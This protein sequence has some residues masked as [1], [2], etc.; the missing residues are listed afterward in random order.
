MSSE[1]QTAAAEPDVCDL[2][3]RALDKAVAVELG[4]AVEHP[5]ESDPPYSSDGL[6]TDDVYAEATR[7]G[8]LIKATSCPVTGSTCWIRTNPKTNTTR[9]PNSET[10][11]IGSSDYRLVAV[12]RAFL[13]AARATKA[14]ANGKET[15]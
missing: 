14:A 4:Y 15:Q 12:C 2:T 5:R 1:T 6:W 11:I 7:R 8:W 9:F 3:G 13:M 10:D